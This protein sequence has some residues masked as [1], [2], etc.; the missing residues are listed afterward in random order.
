MILLYLNSNSY[1][2]VFLQIKYLVDKN[3]IHFH[4]KYYQIR[5][6]EW[7]HYSSNKI[8]K[9]FNITQL[10]ISEKPDGL[11]FSTPGQ[12]EYALKTYV[13]VLHGTNKYL[14]GITK[15]PSNILFIEDPIVFLK[16]YSTKDGINWNHIKK[17]GYSGVYIPD[18]S[19]HGCLPDQD[20]FDKCAKFPG[21]LVFFSVD[22]DSLV[23]WDTDNLEIK[24]IQYNEQGLIHYKEDQDI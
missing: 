19:G 6:M 12:W 5:Q 20:M 21:G 2:W 17:S 3:K 22:C 9:L 7:H 14:Y 10:K 13:R 4:N 11:W 18:L 16:R 8:D 1:L 15:L 24:L 23:F